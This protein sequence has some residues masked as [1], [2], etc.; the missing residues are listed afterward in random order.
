MLRLPGSRATWYALLHHV[1]L[2]L[3]IASVTILAEKF[4]WFLPVDLVTRAAISY[5]QAL[6]DQDT[7]DATI[8]RG[9][10]V[11]WDP[12]AAEDR[13][14]VIVVP[15]LPLQAEQ[16][17]LHPTDFA[18]EL[19]Q[20]IVKQDPAVL[21]IDLDLDP[22]VDD[23]RLNDPA[24]DYLLTGARGSATG[25]TPC[26]PPSDLRTLRTALEARRSLQQTLVA[27][28]S[29]RTALVVTAPPIPFDVRAVDAPR[30]QD[31]VA[32]RILVRQLL[33][34]QELCR[35][36]NVRV[37]LPVADLTNG[38]AFQRDLP[39]LGN[40]A[41]HASREERSAKGDIIVLPF[42]PDVPQGCTP[43]RPPDGI[44]QVASLQDARA[45]V[46][47][48]ETVVRPPAITTIGTISSRYY[49]TMSHGIHLDV[50][51]LKRG[52]PVGALVPSGLKDKVV[53]LGDDRFVTKVLHFDR[54]PVVDFHAAVYYSR[55]HGARSLKHVFAFLLDVVLG[56]ILGVLFTW[57]WA[58]Y[59]RA[60]LAMDGMRASSWR[61][62]VA[63]LP[64]Y[65]RARAVLLTNL[66]SQTALVAGMFA[67]AYVL[68]RWD[69]WINP[70][71]LVLGM[72]IKGLLA[73]R[74]L[75]A[76]HEPEDWWGFYNHHPDV[77]LQA[78]IVIVSLG[79]ASHLGH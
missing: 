22:F 24:C 6:G 10:R 33:W 51:R 12:V 63:K 23:P 38:L 7:R 67:V 4:S 61:E 31:P 65:L 75:H 50:N 30:M 36:A 79:W 64:A 43:F 18:A 60:R 15:N 77:P 62:L 11:E 41:W 76:G 13:P 45:L 72:S 48:M 27:A 37:A 35:L 28:A 47:M 59:S 1:L 44:Q 58:W 20:A 55:L 74:Q 42:V 29:G 53:F 78:L 17:G 54:R 39:T 69:V 73:S 70:L 66:A 46:Q 32:T 57:L 34:I 49:T 21:A 68:L 19:I 3:T 5:V 9:F 71:P 26:G 2:A 16:A 14:R 52:E 56:T 40:M 8:K 25:S